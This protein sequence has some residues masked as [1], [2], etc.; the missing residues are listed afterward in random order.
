[1]TKCWIPLGLFTALMMTGCSKTLPANPATVPAH[2]KVLTEKGE[3]VKYAV[4]MLTPDGPG[5][6]ECEGWIKE[7]G[8]FKL[9]TF[10]RNNN[11]PDGVVPGKYKVH[12]EGFNPTRWGMKKAPA[13]PTPIPDKYKEPKSSP[14]TAEI[15][16][17]DNDLQFKFEK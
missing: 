5:G 8:T 16:S 10:S 11:E 1:M 17:G 14:W 7:D 3:P 4:I 6:V 2:G 12:M 9:Q 15:K 13:D